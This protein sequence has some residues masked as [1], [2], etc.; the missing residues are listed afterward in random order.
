MKS[1]GNITQP[2]TTLCKSFRTI[3]WTERAD[4]AFKDLKKAMTEALVLS[5]PDFS[6]DFTIETD[7]YGNDI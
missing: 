5:L 1:Y 4:K 3:K 2:L 6:Q 7:A